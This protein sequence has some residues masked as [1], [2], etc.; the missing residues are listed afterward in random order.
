MD[1]PNPKIIR[2]AEAAAA[3]SPCA[4]SKR[5]VVVFRDGD[6]VLGSGF[7]GPP[8]GFGCDDSTACRGDCGKRCVHAEMRALRDPNV[9]AYVVLSRSDL[10]ALGSSQDKLRDFAGLD[11]LHVKIGEDG[12]VIAGGGPSC[13]QCSREILDVGFVRGVWLYVQPVHVDRPSQG[14][15]PQVTEY[16]VGNPAWR[17]Y[18]AAEFHR[19][20][21]ETARIS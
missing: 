11:L 4:K 12:K 5:G 19:V 9:M 1:N 8:V 16:P 13:W 18:D 21:C 2:C 14:F 15:F 17:Y 3:R 6:L 7:N 10:R 20:T